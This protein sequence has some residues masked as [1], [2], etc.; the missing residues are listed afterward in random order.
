VKNISLLYQCPLLLKTD[1][2]LYWLL[3]WNIV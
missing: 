3:K 2:D 1:L